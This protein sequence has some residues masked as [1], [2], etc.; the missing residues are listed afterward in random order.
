MGRLALAVCAMAAVGAAAVFSAQG[1]VEATTTHGPSERGFSAF[2]IDPLSPRSVYAGTG[3]GVFK[4]SDSGGNWRAVN[5]GLDDEE[6][7]YVFDLAIDPQEPATIYVGTGSGVF[8]STNGGSSWEE[9]GLSKIAAIALLLNPRNPQVVYAA[10]DD[11]VFES[12]DGGGN[13]R[14][15]TTDPLAIRVFALALDPQRPATVYAGA[16]GGVFKSTNGGAH[17]GP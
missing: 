6:A 7:Q 13:W 8:K 3:S 9:T 2:A 12:S 16:G 5:A 11:G 17:G 14:E 15:V 4:T 1:G 10:T